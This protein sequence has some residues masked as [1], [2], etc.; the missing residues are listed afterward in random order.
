MHAESRIGAKNLPTVLLDGIFEG[1][2][3]I[4]ELIENLRIETFR[5]YKEYRIRSKT[6][7][8]IQNL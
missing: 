1:E 7:G 6:K 5:D 8:D 3:G 4:S 2:K